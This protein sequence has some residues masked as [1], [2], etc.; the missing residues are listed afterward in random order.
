[1]YFSDAAQRYN[2][3]N[4]EY[5]AIEHNKDGRIISYDLK[6][7]KTEVLLSG[8]YFANG[9]ALSDDE[10]YLV[11][12]ES[13][14]QRVSKLHL[15]GEKKGQTEIFADNLPGIPDGVS[16]GSSGIFWVAIAAEKSKFRGFCARPL[17]GSYLFHRT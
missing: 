13:W 7:G 2:V 17:L 8:L 1:M 4:Y 16:K 14:I 6:T 11:Y 9:V 12:N 5:D 3:R 15:N 10:S